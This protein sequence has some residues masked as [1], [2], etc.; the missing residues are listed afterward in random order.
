MTQEQLREFNEYMDELLA[1]E[2]IQRMSQFIQHGNTTS[3]MHSKTV[4]Y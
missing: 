4:A 1:D 2:K 3:L